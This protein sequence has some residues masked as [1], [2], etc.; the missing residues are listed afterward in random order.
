[1]DLWNTRAPMGP[2]Q[3]VGTQKS[4]FLDPFPSQYACAH[5]LNIE[6][7]AFEN[8]L[9]PSNAYTLLEWPLLD[10]HHRWAMNGH[11]DS[12]FDKKY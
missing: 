9:T 7:H 3:I 5:S 1:M 11:M 4:K 6:A 8:P 12:F 2:I 10:Y